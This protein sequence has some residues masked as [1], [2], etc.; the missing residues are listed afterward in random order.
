MEGSGVGQKSGL[1]GF[2][3]LFLWAGGEGACVCAEG[4][5]AKPR[6]GEVRR[7]MLCSVV[8]VRD[9][10]RARARAMPWGRFA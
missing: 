4:A 8:R 6:R 7:A 10:A 9:V 5:R 2:L 3:L 1:A